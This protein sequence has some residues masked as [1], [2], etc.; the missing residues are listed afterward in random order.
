MTIKEL[1]TKE[2]TTKELPIIADESSE[3]ATKLAERMSLHKNACFKAA[4]YNWD[5]ENSIEDV[6]ESWAAQL[7][8]E[9]HQEMEQELKQALMVDQDFEHILVE[10]QQEEEAFQVGLQYA[11]EQQE[12][13]Q[14]QTQQTQ[15]TQESM[16]ETAISRQMGK[17]PV[18][19]NDA[20]SFHGTACQNMSV[21]SVSFLRKI[22]A[23]CARLFKSNAQ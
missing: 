23:F 4:P 21:K 5:G 13:L 18:L 14:Q 19:T 7:E 22:P 9:L 16:N 2:I 10:K 8:Q 3:H 1:T 17:I 12:L 20:A 6:D 15:Q 11:K